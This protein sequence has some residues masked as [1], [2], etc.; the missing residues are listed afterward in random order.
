M[1]AAQVVHQNIRDVW[2]RLAHP[3]YAAM[4]MG[5][6]NLGGVY[7]YRL[8]V[9]GNTEGLSK[10]DSFVLETKSGKPVMTLAVEECTPPSSIY[11][12]NS[13]K[14]DRP[15]GNCVFQLKFQLE[16]YGEGRTK[17]KVMYTAILKNQFLE[18]VTLLSPS[19]LIYGFLIRRALKKLE[20]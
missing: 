1:E 15:G 19:S 8:E 17:V 10:G 12:S 13:G 16:E 4:F 7:R 18:I 11:Y 2:K 20:N 9:S 14:E 5:T 6:V 3:D